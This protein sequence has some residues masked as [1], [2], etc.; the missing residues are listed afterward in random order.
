M[1]LVFGIGE[2]GGGLVAGLDGLCQSGLVVLGEQRIPPDVPQVELDEVGVVAIPTLHRHRRLLLVTVASRRR[3]GTRVWA[4]C[5]VISPQSRGMGRSLRSC[6]CTATKIAPDTA[7]TRS[8]ATARSARSCVVRD[9]RPIPI[10]LVVVVVRFSCRFGWDSRAAHAGYGP[11]HVPQTAPGVTAPSHSIEKRHRPTRRAPHRLPPR[12]AGR[13]SAGRPRAMIAAVRPDGACLVAT[14]PRGPT[15]P[16]RRR[17]DDPDGRRL[18]RPG[19]G[20]ARPARPGWDAGRSVV[21]RPAW[22]DPCRG[23][24]GRC[25]PVALPG[26]RAVAK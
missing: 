7:V 22:G 23:A 11:R 15:A 13:R 5:P 4:P 25:G 3:F 9:H 16:P 14:A 24:G 18:D 20:P 21:G 8:T 26:A 17:R 1:G 19:P 12:G 2:G 6:M 10:V